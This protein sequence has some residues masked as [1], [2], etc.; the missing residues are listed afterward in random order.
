[1]SK[2]KTG[3][4]AYPLAVETGPDFYGRK[5]HKVEQGMTLRDYFAAKAMS[6]LQQRGFQMFEKNEEDLPDK[7]IA[8]EAYALADAM[9][10]A[11][12]H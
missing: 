9:L 5:S 11:R 12:G 8:R 2:I 4:P 1:M 7:S 6:A 3:G 10:A